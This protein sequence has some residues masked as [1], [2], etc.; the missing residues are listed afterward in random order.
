M[1]RGQSLSQCRRLV[2]GKEATE[3]QRWKLRSSSGNKKK[4]PKRTR[5]QIAR[6]KKKIPQDDRKKKGG[7]KDKNGK[8]RLDEQKTDIEAKNKRE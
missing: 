1:K 6:Q 8:Q 5:R 2:T 3:E 7:N 4:F